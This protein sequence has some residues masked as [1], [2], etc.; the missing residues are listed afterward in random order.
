M[1]ICTSFNL[2]LLVSFY[3]KGNCDIKERFHCPQFPQVQDQY[4]KVKV[5]WLPT[6]RPKICLHANL[7]STKSDAQTKRFMWP[8][9][10]QVVTANG[11]FP[12]RNH[13][14]RWILVW[15]LEM[16]P[17]VFRELSSYVLSCSCF[18][19]SGQVSKDLT[20]V[21]L[22]KNTESGPRQEWLKNH[23]IHWN[24]PSFWH[25][26]ACMTRS[27]LNADG[28]DCEMFKHKIHMS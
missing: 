19:M 14:Q 20:V 15:F 8:T 26:Y 2:P 11:N 9:R 27:H 6:L 25:I 22:W 18:R 13:R 5:V 12:I 7:W 17:L 24:V 4:L 21:E 1:Y 10:C 16:E 28:H 23:L 3:I